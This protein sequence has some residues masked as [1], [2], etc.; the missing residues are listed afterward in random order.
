MGIILT[1]SGPSGVGKKT[2]AK[3]LLAK[4]SHV[5]VVQSVTTR[6][7]RQFD[8]YGE[9][10]HVS[11]G[12]FETMDRRN[13]FLWTTEYAGLRYGTRKE[14]VAELFRDRHAIG[15]MFLV[16][17]VLPLLEGY[18]EK[19]PSLAH[20]HVKVFVTAPRTV[21]EQRLV[22]QGNEARKVRNKLEESSTWEMIAKY[23]TPRFHFVSNDRKIQETVEEVEALLSR[24]HS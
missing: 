19:F 5:K 8:M 17:D 13:T 2:I 23:V 15:V 4:N 14:S 18:L 9:Y 3:L 10:R 6:P 21:L 16:P 7:P 1:L 24:Q 22:T 11:P 12:E 20:A